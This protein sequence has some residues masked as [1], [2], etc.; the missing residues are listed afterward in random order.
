[1]VSVP[2]LV[3]TDDVDPGQTLDGRELLDEDPGPGSAGPREEEGHGREQDEPLGDEP[4]DPGPDD[5][6]LPP[7]VAD[8]VPLLTRS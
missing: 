3:E 2:G 8:D 1:M 5:D 7:L 4:H 6:A